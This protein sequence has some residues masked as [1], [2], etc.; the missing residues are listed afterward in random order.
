MVKTMFKIYNKIWATGKFSKLWAKSLIVTI[1]K[2]GDATKCEKN[3]TISL[4]CHANR[5]LL[6][7]IRKLLNRNIENQKILFN[8]H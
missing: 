1:P 8:F 6:Q 2:K 3:C 7:I 4:I 5:V